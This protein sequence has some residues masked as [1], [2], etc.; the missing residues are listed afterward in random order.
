MDFEWD[1]I[2]AKSNLLKHGIDFADAA[3]VLDDELAITIADPKVDHEERFVT[4]GM[5]PDGRLAVVVYTWRDERIRLI[6][7]RRATS[8]ERR[9]YE[10]Q[11]G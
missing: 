6:S 10:R 2:K 4:I 7:A 3:V 8:A 9:H 11:G 5:T 1:P